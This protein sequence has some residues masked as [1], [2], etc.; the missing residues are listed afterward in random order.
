MNEHAEAPTEA[1]MK[2]ISLVWD[3]CLR[4]TTIW[5]IGVAA[6]IVAGWMTSRSDIDSL[7][8]QINLLEARISQ[9]K[10]PVQHNEQNVTLEQGEGLLERETRRLIA[11]GK[12]GDL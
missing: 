4:L 10:V 1:E 11:K 5:G 12:Y 6:L 7:R 2:T 8:S 9:I 3:V